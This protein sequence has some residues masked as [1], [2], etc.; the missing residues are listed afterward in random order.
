MM[1]ARKALYGLVLL[2]I[3][4]LFA[5]SLAKADVQAEAIPVPSPTDAA[6]EASRVLRV[7]GVGLLSGST[8]AQAQETALLNAY[9]RMMEAGLQAWS[10]G[11]SVSPVREL[12]R[13]FRID[14]QHPNDRLLGWVLRSRMVHQ[15]RAA[16]RVTVELESPPVGELSS[17]YP[18]LLHTTTKDVD[19]DG[20]SETVGAGYD[21]RIY[22]LKEQ[23]RG[24][25]ILGS[26]PSYA[27]YQAS[28]ILAPDGT[29]RERVKLARIDSILS[30]EDAGPN[31]ARVVARLTTREEVDSRY[32]GGAEEQREIVVSLRAQDEGPT[33]ELEEPYDFTG[34]TDP[35]QVLR[36]RV[37]A[38]AGLKRSAVSLNGRRLWETPDGLEAKRLSLDLELALEP[39]LNRVTIEA[40]D[41]EGRS[42]T[43][44]LM[45]RLGASA[46]II[47]TSRRFALLAGAP[48]L[49]RALT[50]YGAFPE[51]QVV[52]VP[53]RPD[54]ATLEQA[55]KALIA[56]SEPGDLLVLAV[57]GTAAPAPAGGYAIGLADGTVITA[58]ELASLAG[59]LQGRRLL[60]LLELRNAKP[61]WLDTNDMLTRLERSGWVAL[62]W[63]DAEPRLFTLV[64]SGLGG[65]ADL[66]GDRLIELQELYDYV[67][68]QPAGNP[69][70][71]R[72]HLLGRPAIS[73]FA[74][75]N[76]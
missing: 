1:S 58:A 70:L 14:A 66:D 57:S 33:V 24:W 23:D 71:L 72:G 75:P 13:P 27:S 56:D 34:V 35:S 39:G 51:N 21:G 60:A 12:W 61:S 44:E 53:E 50:S 5:H 74:A 65:A 6:A 76:K 8:P 16:D 64:A 36:G 18:H 30:V 49:G 73:H 59:P 46:P 40:V 4:V 52:V 32:A 7:E 29:V 41:R 69:P 26:T 19:G 25:D 47:D 37:L 17:A 31:R 67:F 20:L 45:V 62:G 3:A 38:P 55:L 43:R 22:V 48:A 9:R 68:R 54:R 11:L 2:A 63:V 42:T 28:T 15:E 10:F